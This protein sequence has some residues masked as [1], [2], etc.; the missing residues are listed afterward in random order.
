MSFKSLTGG[1][2]AKHSAQPSPCLCHA[3]QARQAWIPEQPGKV[4]KAFSG[5]PC[6][7][8]AHTNLKP[9]LSESL[10]RKAQRVENLS[11]GSTQPHKSIPRQ[12]WQLITAVLVNLENCGQRDAKPVGTPEVLL[13][14]SFKWVLPEHSR[15]SLVVWVVTNREESWNLQTIQW[16]NFQFSTE[17]FP[18]KWTSALCLLLPPHHSSPNKTRWF[19]LCLLPSSRGSEG[20]RSGHTFCV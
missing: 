11:K 7:V 20:G 13:P 6:S 9:S 10:M 12:K 19:A 14:S 16:D 8:S 4:W 1:K 15:F 18:Q 3:G 17:K 2:K 5:S